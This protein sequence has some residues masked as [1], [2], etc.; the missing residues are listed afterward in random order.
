MPA[1]INSN[2]YIQTAYGGW[3]PCIE[4]NNQYGLRP[5]PGSVLPNCVGYTVG[6]F[7]ELLH[8]GACTWL[9]SV[10]AKN[11]LALAISQ[12]LSWGDDPVV[13]GVVCFD[14]SADGHCYVIEQVIDNDTVIASE[15]GWNYTTAPVV[16]TFTRTRSGGVWQYQAGY[17]YQGIIYPPHAIGSAEDYYMLFL[18]EEGWK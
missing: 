4:G 18:D 15:S 6:R 14:S 12:G 2:Y 10:D 8:E 3:S 7:N 17:T 11:Q 9:G 13:G 16:K 1:D 5:F